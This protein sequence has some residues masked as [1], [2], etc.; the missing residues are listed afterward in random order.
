MNEVRVLPTVVELRAAV[1]E[2]RRAGLSVALV[3]TM[4]ALHR[5]HVRLVE[6]GLQLAD[7]V[8]T[9]IF[10]NPTQFSPQEDLARYPRDL[11]GDLAQLRAVGCHAAFVPDAA[12]MYP[13]GFS[14]SVA[15]AGL[16]TGLCAERRPH[17]FGG[18]ATVVTK[19]LNQ[20][21]ADC[22]IFGEK[23]YQQLL[24]VRRLARDLD[25]GT[26]IVGTPIVREPDGL[27][28][29]SRNRYL[30]ATSRQIAPALQRELSRAARDLE[31]GAEVAPTLAAA[32]T[33]ILDAGFDEV[34]YLE[35]R[36]AADLRPLGVLGSDD[37]RLLAAARLGPVRLIDNV[38]VA[39]AGAALGTL[40]IG[41]GLEPGA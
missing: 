31:A 30:D 22:A 12:E 29:S 3:P 32:R 37:G 34:E 18:V 38:A 10:V 21:R 17:H 13:T 8:V 41:P 40:C 23:D 24:V 5:G 6:V 15:V 9:S 19:L 25:T 4:G 28:L 20:A 1:A 7:R 14:T 36:D 39:G 16:T 11:E 35:L 2:W 26:E 27:A 33:A